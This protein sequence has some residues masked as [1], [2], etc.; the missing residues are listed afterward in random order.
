MKNI[1]PAKKQDTLQDCLICE[2]KK[3]LGIHLLNYF[4]CVECEHDIVKSDTSDQS[5]TYYL[6]RLR[7]VKQALLPISENN[8][9]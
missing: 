6:G 4:I 8:N 7:K 3:D 1:L 9:I 2:E 5:Y